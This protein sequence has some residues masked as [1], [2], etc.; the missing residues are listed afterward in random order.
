MK[1]NV[2]KHFRFKLNTVLDSTL[3]RFKWLGKHV[4]LSFA[5]HNSFKRY[6]KNT[7]IIRNFKLHS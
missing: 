3:G 5:Y 1:T 4:R 6:I 7:R 2:E